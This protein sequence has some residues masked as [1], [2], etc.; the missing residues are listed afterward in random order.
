M[1]LTF[2]LEAL[3]RAPPRRARTRILLGLYAG[4][5]F[6]ASIAMF[7]A[8]GYG[9][10]RKTPTGELDSRRPPPA[11]RC[12]GSPR[13]SPSSAAPLSSSWRSGRW[14]VGDGRFRTHNAAMNPE[15]TLSIGPISILSGSIA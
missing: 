6:V 8:G 3:R 11:W 5:Q 9:A 12:M 10:A 4:G 14:G 7:V 13:S 15:T 2:G 1:L